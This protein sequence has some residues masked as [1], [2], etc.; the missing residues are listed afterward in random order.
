MQR[1]H[2]D[3]PVG[4][5]TV[6]PPWLCPSLPTLQ[7]ENEAVG[8]TEAKA[9]AAAGRPPTPP[10]GVTEPS[11]GR[12][13]TPANLDKADDPDDPSGLFPASLAA[14]EVVP[15]ASEAS[16]CDILVDLAVEQPRCRST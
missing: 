13:D 15:E 12:A 9:S 11:D 14:G 16:V 10:G 6:I 5:H 2:A 8:A 3:G 4:V 1:N 7:E